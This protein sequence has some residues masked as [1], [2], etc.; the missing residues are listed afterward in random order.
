MVRLIVEDT[1]EEET[2]TEGLFNRNKTDKDN[3]KSTEDMISVDIN[4]LDEDE[5]FQ[6]RDIFQYTLK[7]ASIVKK[8]NNRLSAIGAY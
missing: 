6:L 2:T 1:E 5:L 3:P 8:I 7:D 4:A